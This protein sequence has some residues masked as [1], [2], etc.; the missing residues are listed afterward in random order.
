MSEV[1]KI[2]DLNAGIVF[3]K[4][5]IEKYSPRQ[6]EK[7]ARGT[8]DKIAD[9]VL[10]KKASDALRASVT[11]QIKKE[12]INTPLTHLINSTLLFCNKE[13]GRST[14]KLTFNKFR[15]SYIL[16]E[17]VKDGVERTTIKDKDAIRVILSSK[18]REKIDVLHIPT[19]TEN[20]RKIMLVGVGEGKRKRKPDLVIGFANDGVTIERIDG[21]EA[22]KNQYLL[23][24]KLD[25]KALKRIFGRLDIVEEIAEFKKALEYNKNLTLGYLGNV[26]P[27][28]CQGKP[29]SALDIAVKNAYENSFY[30]PAN[31]KCREAK[32]CLNEVM[33]SYKLIGQ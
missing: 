33:K 16:T 13:S 11:P 30:F 4:K 26:L 27:K 6:T 10:S 17:Q 14:K 3:S 15:N 5:L 21:K 12:K 25:D 2:M 28:K 1:T 9:E 18:D 7:M 22:K 29:L 24:Q 32:A 19:E 20:H 31:E 8:I 23:G